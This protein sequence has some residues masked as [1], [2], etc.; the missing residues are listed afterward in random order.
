MRTFPIAGVLGSLLIAAAVAIVSV[1]GAWGQGSPIAPRASISPLPAGG[2]VPAHT[3]ATSVTFVSTPSAYV[4]GTAP[5][6]RRPCSV[7]LRTRDRGSSW[8]G[9]PAPRQRVSS[10]Y[11]SGLWGLRFADLREGFA[12]GQGLWETTNGSASWRRVSAPTRFVVDLAAV[13]N[14]ELVMV[15]A[16]CQFGT[17]GCAGRLT[18]YHRA[19]GGGRWQ[20]SAT[21][22]RSALNESLAVHGSTVWVLAGTQ[23]WVSTNGG[24]SFRSHGQP[25]ARTPSGLPMPTSLTSVGA[26]SYLLCTGQGFLSHTVKFVYETA[27]TN[28]AWKL[29]GKPPTP[30]DGGMLAA[31]SDHAIVIATASAASWLYLSR[32]S[33]HAW[34]TPL[35]FSDGGDGWGDLGF[36]T[37]SDGVVI[38]APARTDGGSAN[39]PGQLELS[40]DGGQTW[41]MAAF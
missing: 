28:S 24:R 15:G 31:G 26:H 1:S 22:A 9:L 6:A 20:V 14:R 36:T 18:I 19:L 29:V 38:H 8:V 7:I 41:Q 21:T 2:P 40:S 37:A 39:F 32:A 4:L 27:G 17:T 34:T 3:S 10:A 30:G 35:S 33:G 25:C 16:R 5:C 13:R 12:F 11:G 23:L